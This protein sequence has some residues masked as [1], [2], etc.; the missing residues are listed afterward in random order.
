MDALNIT[1]LL[2]DMMA[3]ACYPLEPQFNVIQLDSP[4][5]ISNN[6]SMPKPA[7]QTISRF[8]S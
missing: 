2:D 3:K 6:L 8:I 1:I 5:K 4:D 7:V